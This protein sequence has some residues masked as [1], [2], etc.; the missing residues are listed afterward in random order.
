M[1]ERVTTGILKMFGWLGGSLG[2]GPLGHVPILAVLAWMMLAAESV[3]AQRCTAKMGELLSVQGRVQVKHAG[4]VNWQPVLSG[5]EFCPGDSL[6]VEALGRAA[7]LLRPETILRLD[8]ETTITFPAEV[9]GKESWLDMLG[10]AAHFISRWPRFKRIR[11]PYVN[12]AIE[13]TEFAL[14]VGV[15]ST[16]LWVLEGRVLASNPYGG[17]S[18]SGGEAVVARAGQ[19]PVRPLRIRPRDAVQWALHYPP[20]IDLQ[21]ALQR[22]GAASGTIDR[23]LE[24]HQRGEMPEALSELENI[25]AASR[26]AS[27]HTLR[28]S[29][30][31]T[32][33]RVEEADAE[34]GRALSLDEG[35][36]SALALRSV[37][38]LAGN[39]KGQALGYA[40]CAVERGPGAAVPHIALSYVQQANFEI[41]AALGSVEEAL[42]LDA[43]NALAWARLAELQLSL[44]E[45]P[46]ALAAARQAVSRD[47][48]LARGHAVLGY[49]Y[50]AM[51][52]TEAARAAFVRAIALDEADP[53]PR[54]GVGLAMIR[55]DELAAGRQEIELAAGLD[56]ME[57]LIRSY[58]GKAY[59]EEHRTAL[60]GEQ[61]AMAKELD[62]RD[63]TPWFYDAIRKQLDNRPVDAFHDLQRSIT[64]NDNRAVY[65]SRLLLDGDLA[66]RSA[67][68]GQI[69]RDLGFEQPALVEGW[70]SVNIDPANH[71]AH[72][73]LAEAYAST[74]RSGLAK[75]SELL[76]SQL[77]Q[78]LSLSPVQPQLATS[79][80]LMLENAGP[81]DPAFNE[82]TSLFERSRLALQASV[83]GGNQET[84]GEEVTLAGLTK[85]MAYSVGQFHYRTAGF[86]PNSDVTQDIQDIFVQASLSPTLGLQAEY[87]HRKVDHG[88]L[89]L[90]FVPDPFGLVR[91]SASTDSLRLGMKF[92]PV[93]ESDALF[94]LIR[95][96]ARE[97]Q[98]YRGLPLWRTEGRGYIGE[99]QYLTRAD[100]YSLV[101]GAGRFHADNDTN[102]PGLD[103]NTLHDNAY[104][105]SYIP[106]ARGMNWTL[107][108]SLDA[109]RD[110]VI[111]D[112]DRLNPKLGL[113]WSGDSGTTFRFAAYKMLKRNLIA[114]QTL[115]PTQVAGFNQFYDDFDGTR[116]TRIGVGADRR[117]FSGL[118]GGVEWS[119]RNLDVPVGGAPVI[120]EDWREQ[121]TRA[122]LNLTPYK[123]W[124]LSAE[125]QLER[126]ARARKLAAGSLLTPLET[127]THL[128]PLEARYFHPSGM[129]A[130]F[131]ATYVRQ[132][133]VLD[134]GGTRRSR[135]GLVDAGMG[136]RLP[137]RLGIVSMEVRNMLDQG[138]N[139]QDLT[140]R[141]AQQLTDPPFPPFLPERTI[142]FTLTLSL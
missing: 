37:I 115:E 35:D 97:D 42:R 29:M 21:A 30:L 49:A 88:N 17:L 86:R 24:R 57:P 101:T 111:G 11:T 63:P 92:K 138:F 128:L 117:V 22:S 87:R 136:W 127:N 90:Q 54:L 26:T 91:R 123:R 76:Q 12:A 81:G 70:K 131:G 23:V 105:Y 6:R 82:F 43:D 113:T 48:G 3:A 44:G 122:Y 116:F 55:D 40:R 126:F 28:A 51:F 5:A 25:P 53:L 62:S 79:N 102:I 109:L 77:L 41:E 59:F 27:W 61:Y 133:A 104:L 60:A 73:F 56:P 132:R 34:I 18:V 130:R 39:Q 89:E 9:T 118:H 38:A 14:R 125:Y 65:R 83:V 10:G 58:L 141:T 7:V 95:M 8:Q 75:V 52:D 78:P 2:T 36:D 72:R 129:F 142:Q 85:R 96:D 124:V 94:S 64:L 69:Y 31:L 98:Q 110:G 99:A 121:V 16:E 137:R 71:S 15:D 120:A 114:G 45:T 103:Y 119:E 1:P 47:P 140:S 112:F 67:S 4:A 13:G 108:V 100:R 80:L 32:V 20:L 93:K 139:Y 46:R 33:G 50:L 107:G 74:P 135:F 66:A 106:G 134:S 84:L 19:A 68:L